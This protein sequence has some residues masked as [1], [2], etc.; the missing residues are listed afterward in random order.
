MLGSNDY[1]DTMNNKANS[2]EHRDIPTLK[3]L[4]TEFDNLKKE[5][6]TTANTSARATKKNAKKGHNLCKLPPNVLMLIC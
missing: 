2:S 5:Q 4:R 6:Q 3:A 1:I